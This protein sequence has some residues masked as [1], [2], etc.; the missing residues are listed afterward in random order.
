MSA[1]V[2]YNVRAFDADG[3]QVAMFPVRAVC[4]PSP[5]QALDL[6]REQVGED[7]MAAECQRSVPAKIG[8]VTPTTRRVSARVK[9]LA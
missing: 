9:V 6:A 3:Q 4:M 5:Q 8:R 1:Y 2:T 7:V